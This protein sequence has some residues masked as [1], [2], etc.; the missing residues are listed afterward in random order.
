MSMFAVRETYFIETPNSLML[1][2]TEKLFNVVIKI[3]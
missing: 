1:V 3:L 2:L